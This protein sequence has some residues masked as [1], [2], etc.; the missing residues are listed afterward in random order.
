VLAFQH[1]PRGFIQVPGQKLGAPRPLQAPSDAGAF[2]YKVDDPILNVRRLGPGLKEIELNDVKGLENLA[3]ASC[4]I[5]QLDVPILACGSYP[6]QA[7][8]GVGFGRHSCDTD[9][10]EHLGHSQDEHFCAGHGLSPIKAG[11]WLGI[12][13]QR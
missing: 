13:P 7:S 4:D 12:P 1:L 6:A 5:A 2:V 11:E 10:A 9:A 3:V 8:D